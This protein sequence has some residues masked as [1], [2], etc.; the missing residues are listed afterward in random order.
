MADPR[1]SPFIQAIEVGCEAEVRR[2]LAKGADPNEVDV[3]GW[4]A[5]VIAAA[6]GH[7]GVLQA[8]AAAGA[9][10]EELHRPP[11]RTHGGR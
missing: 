5:V 3:D 10:L 11:T 8:L 1:T 2:M 7:N 6:E 4:P 9:D